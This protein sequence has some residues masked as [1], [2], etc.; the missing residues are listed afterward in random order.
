MSSGAV[1]VPKTRRNVVTVGE[2]PTEIVV[3][4]FEDTIFVVITQMKKLG[5][6]ILSVPERVGTDSCLFESQVL[7]GRRDDPLLVLYARQLAEEISKQTTFDR[8]LLVCI[9]LRD[10]GRTPQAFQEIINEVLS[11]SIW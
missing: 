4:G 7:F 3:Q 10:E 8:K 11:L 1:V 9:A 2:I 5:S 6:M